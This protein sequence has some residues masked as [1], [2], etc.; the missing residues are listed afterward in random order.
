MRWRG[1]QAIVPDKIPQPLSVHIYCL[2]YK[3]FEMS[4]NVLVQKKMALSY[5]FQV[6]HPQ[7]MN[8]HTTIFYT[9]NCIGDAV[10]SPACFLNVAAKMSNQKKQTMEQAAKMTPEANAL[11]ST[12]WS[13]GDFIT[14]TGANCSVYELSR[15][16]FTRAVFNK[17]LTWPLIFLIRHYCRSSV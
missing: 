11:S 12:L 4:K 1:N 10:I 2:E 5:H 16:I 8:Q 15:N 6:H 14:V 17:L 7:I 13:N 3:F 9:I